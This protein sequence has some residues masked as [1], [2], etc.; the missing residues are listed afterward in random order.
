MPKLR[1]VTVT[2]RPPLCGEFLR[3]ED[4]TAASKER[5]WSPVPATAPTV[6]TAA[7]QAALA[8][9][10]AHVTIVVV[11]HLAVE[12]A[13]NESDIDAVISELAKFKPSTLT[14]AAP[15]RGE[16]RNACDAIG[17]S[18]V[19][20]GLLVPAT[21]ETVMYSCVSRPTAGGGLHVNAVMEVHTAEV[22][23]LLASD[24][25]VVKSELPKFN[26]VTVRDMPM[27]V[28]MLETC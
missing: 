22:H 18:Y 10:D 6:T 14:E 16:F 3:T 12:Q 9:P 21:A 17:A 11:V 24:N 27:V 4:C 8:V 23:M 20:T 1:P 28:G 19:N 2:E 25:E 7:G 5:I 26:P 15:E 13:P